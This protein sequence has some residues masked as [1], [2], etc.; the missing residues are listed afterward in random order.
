MGR[1]WDFSEICERKLNDFEA[2]KQEYFN[3]QQAFDQQISYYQAQIAEL[4]KKISEVEEQKASLNST[5]TLPAQDIVDQEILKGITHGEKALELKKWIGQLQEK[6]D[7]L[8]SM[9][10]HEKTFFE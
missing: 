4:T 2:K 9:I 10:D 3:K 5:R 1:E 8:E 7:L 6:R